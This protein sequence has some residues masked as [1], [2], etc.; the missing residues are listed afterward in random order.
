[1]HG[2]LR[3]LMCKQIRV[4]GS[5]RLSGEGCVNLEAWEITPVSV[6]TGQP[7]LSPSHWWVNLIQ[8]EPCPLG[9]VRDSVCW[10]SES[11]Y[12]EF[13]LFPSSYHA[14]GLV[15]VYPPR[16]RLLINPSPCLFPESPNRTSAVFVSPELTVLPWQVKT[17]NLNAT[18]TECPPA[19]SKPHG[20]CGLPSCTGHW[21]VMVR[22][23]KLSR[24]RLLPTMWELL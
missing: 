1:M 9:G 22:K 24:N 20:E 5:K 11:Q 12:S 23:A 2:L 6:E 18:D 13:I 14:G 3:E 4:K 16:I 21:E 10:D 17:R 15:S 7:L 19:I 8:Q